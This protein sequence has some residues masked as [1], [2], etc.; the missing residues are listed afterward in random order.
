MTIIRNVFCEEQ[1]FW[2]FFEIFYVSTN[3]EY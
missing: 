2:A 1:Y 3:F